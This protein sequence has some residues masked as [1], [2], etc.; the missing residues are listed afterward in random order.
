MH[1][2]S[3]EDSNSDTKMEDSD[4]GTK[5]ENSESANII[6]AY[7]SHDPNSDFLFPGN[8]DPQARSLI[9]NFSILQVGFMPFA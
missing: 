6:S 4:R 7:E 2:F 3:A 5:I 8:L 9:L 1:S